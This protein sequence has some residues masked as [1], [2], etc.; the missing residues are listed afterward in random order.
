MLLYGTCMRCGPSLYLP[1]SSIVKRNGGTFDVAM[2]HLLVLCTRSDYCLHQ[3]TGKICHHI[4]HFVYSEH[5]IAQLAN[6]YQ[7]LQDTA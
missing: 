4:S 5:I 2:L 7:Y 3:Q 1:D 6:C